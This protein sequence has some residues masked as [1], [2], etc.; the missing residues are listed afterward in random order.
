MSADPKVIWQGE[1]SGSSYRIVQ[2]GEI[3][4]PEKRLPSDA[5][6]NVCWQF[7]QWETG[8]ASEL[9]RSLLQARP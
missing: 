9:L 2:S 7:T 3:F 5:L 1:Y 8:W 4:T 6:G